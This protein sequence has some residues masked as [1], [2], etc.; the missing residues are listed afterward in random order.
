MASMREED[1]AARCAAARVDIEDLL[2]GPE[3]ALSVDRIFEGAREAFRAGDTELISDLD[4]Q[5]T[6]IESAL[7][8]LRAQLVG[9][10]W[11]PVNEE[12]YP[13]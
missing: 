2:A 3:L 1:F 13:D 11:L 9:P 5:L 7:G 6:E 12:N 10:E 8:H 4:R